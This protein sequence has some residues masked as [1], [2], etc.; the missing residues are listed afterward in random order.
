[1]SSMVRTYFETIFA[2]F[3]CQLVSQSSSMLHRH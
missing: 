3:R 2:A 1:V